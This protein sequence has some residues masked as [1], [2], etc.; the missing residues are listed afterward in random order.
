MNR[1]KSPSLRYEIKYKQNID[2]KMLLRLIKSIPA[3]FRN[4]YPPR[5]VNSIY[6]DDETFFSY[7]ENINGNSYREKYRVRWYGTF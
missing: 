7:N 1:N 4:S 3:N 6:L 2:I 5:D